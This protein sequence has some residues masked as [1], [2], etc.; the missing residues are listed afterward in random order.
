[1]P[2]EERLAPYHDEFPV[3]A[4][5]ILVGRLDCG[6]MSA[7]ALTMTTVVAWRKLRIRDAAA[8]HL[9]R[10]DDIVKRILLCSEHGALRFHKAKGNSV[11]LEGFR[12]ERGEERRVMEDEV[13]KLKIGLG[14]SSWDLR[15][16]ATNIESP[17][18]TNRLRSTARY[19]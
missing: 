3:L 18:I 6:N 14:S 9:I 19:M 13:R 7:I 8:C 17:R 2:Y 10:T 12:V 16:C 4:G 5:E 1:M 15:A 11:G